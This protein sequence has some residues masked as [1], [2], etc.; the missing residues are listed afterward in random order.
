[1]STL[2]TSAARTV[3]FQFKAT[4]KSPKLRENFTQEFSVDLPYGL[5]EFPEVCVILLD[6][7]E[8]Q[9]KST[10]QSSPADF[11]PPA[12]AFSESAIRQLAAEISRPSLRG[13]RILSAAALSACATYYASQAKEILGK[14]EKAAEF[15]AEVL[16]KK[17]S[18]LVSRPEILEAFAEVFA[19]IPEP[20][21]DSPI[22]A[23]WIALADLLASLLSQSSEL[24]LSA[25]SF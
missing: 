15:G 3:S 20:D 9:V 21:S 5:S 23:A 17:F 25:D 11:I 16:R 8:K 19:S 18:P 4:A 12:D 7:L 6:A 1:M 2:A 10:V 24:E 13:Q 22:S 14:S